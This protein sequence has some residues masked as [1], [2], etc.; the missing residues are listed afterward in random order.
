MAEAS[1]ENEPFTP[2]R[3]TVLTTN[4]VGLVRS[5]QAVTND[6]RIKSS[7]RPIPQLG[8]L[9]DGG[10][11]RPLTPE[12]QRIIGE[13]F[14]KNYASIELELMIRVALETGA[15]Q[16]TVCTLSIGCIK[17][18]FEELEASPS[19]DNVVI[20]AG[21]RYKADTK[22]GRLNRL[23]FRRKLIND[24][25]TYVYC[26]RAE[27]RR[28]RENS[29]YFETDENY[30]F[31]TRDGN[32]Y[33]TAQREVLDRQDPMAAWNINA[34]LMVPKNGQSLRNELGRFVARIQKDEPGFNDFSF[35]DLRATMGMNVVRALR[36]KGY[37]DSKIFDHVR[38]RLNHSD[39]KTTELYLNF[40]AELSE[41]NNIQEEF[42]S[43]IYPEGGDE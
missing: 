37:P 33:L 2:I 22:G 16:Q 40:D 10:S 41:F 12:E 13:G 29:F 27:K 11:L 39:I 30:V 4:R 38:Q 42:G 43:I 26:E 23:I 24:L 14:R 17:R 25:M 31:L 8:K 20:N 1:L 6:L 9:R 28:S 7:R 21:Q 36:R 15:R 5:I 19:M 34:P 18:A 32:P 3:K 35:H